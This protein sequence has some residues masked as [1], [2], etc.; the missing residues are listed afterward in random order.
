[1]EGVAD[2][3]WVT[4]AFPKARFDEQQHDILRFTFGLAKAKL[5][6]NGAHTHEL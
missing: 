2:V 4:I 5:R 3:W 1:M 6:E